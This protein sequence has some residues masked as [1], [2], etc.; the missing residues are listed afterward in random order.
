MTMFKWL[1]VFYLDAYFILLWI[2]FGCFRYV[3]VWVGVHERK[4]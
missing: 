1:V 4:Y 2:A 3:Y